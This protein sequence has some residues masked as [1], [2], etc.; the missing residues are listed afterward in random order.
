MSLEQR[1]D[2]HT[3]RYAMVTSRFQKE[4]QGEEANVGP[5]A[6]FDHW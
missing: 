5:V 2:G 4:T 3:P 1:K 6:E